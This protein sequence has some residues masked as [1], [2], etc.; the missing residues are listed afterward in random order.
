MSIL[1]TS[2]CPESTVKELGIKNWPIWTCGVSSFDWTYEDKE[3]CLVLEGEVTVS[4]EGGQPINFRAGDLVTFPAGMNCRW[5]VH[6]AVRK[7]YR[8]GD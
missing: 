5:E 3:T 6:K 4:P 7:H 8:F 2:P 1:V